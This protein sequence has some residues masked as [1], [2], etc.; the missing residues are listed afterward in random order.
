ML[1]WLPLCLPLRRSRC[2]SFGLA[3]RNSA[4]PSMPPT[5]VKVFLISTRAGSLG[6]NLQA[7]RVAWRSLLCG[8]AMPA[9]HVRLCTPGLVV[10]RGLSAVDADCCWFSTRVISAVSRHGHP[11]RSRLQPVCGRTGAL[12]TALPARRVQTPVQI[13]APQPTVAGWCPLGLIPSRPPQS[14]PMAYSFFLSSSSPACSLECPDHWPCTCSPCFRVPQC[15]HDAELPAR[16]LALCRQ[17]YVITLCMAI[18]LT[19]C[20]PQDLR[21]TC[22]SVLRCRRRGGHTGWAR[23]P[24]S[25]STSCSPRRAFT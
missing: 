24:R 5:Q 22:R 12:M 1:A 10:W 23:S 20:G 19:P 4:T 6:I 16:Q 7:S 18:P 13:P 17:P 25:W 8:T 2:S 14:T 21:L 11:V 15:L 9:W 3:P